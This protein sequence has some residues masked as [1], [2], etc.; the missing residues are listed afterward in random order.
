MQEVI[1]RQND[2]YSFQLIQNTKHQR[3]ER[4]VNAVISWRLCSADGDLQ[5]GGSCKRITSADAFDDHNGLQG[6]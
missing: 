6:Q 2:A 1:N 3:T 4:P 5:Y